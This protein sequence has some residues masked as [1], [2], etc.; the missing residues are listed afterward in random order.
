MKP[1]LLR[2]NTPRQT[3]NF[4]QIVGGTG[5][6]RSTVEVTGGLVLLVFTED[7]LQ[8]LFPPPSPFPQKR[9]KTG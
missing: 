6:G 4:L 3:P 7:G 2:T 1:G 9:T 5:D 8:G